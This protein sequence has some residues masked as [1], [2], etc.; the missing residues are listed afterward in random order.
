VFG[1][2]HFTRG[3][4]TADVS[5]RYY[6]QDTPQTMNPAL[7]STGFVYALKPA[8]QPT[9][10]LAQTVGARVTLAPT[11][12][13]HH[14]VT[15][16][17]DRINIDQTQT[18]PR[19]T[20]PADTFFTASNQDLTKTSIGYNTSVEGAL[21]RATTGSLTV[22]FDHYSRPE[23]FWY[24]GQATA[25]NMASGTFDSPFLQ[26]TA[27]S[28]TGYFAQAQVAFHDALFLTGGVRAER[29]SNFG[30]SLGT[31]VSPQFGLTFVHSVGAA[32]VK[33]RG[34]W[35]RAIRPPSPGEKAASGGVSSGYINLANPLLAPER[36]QGGDIGIDAVFGT[37][38]SLSV[39]YF[40]QTAE[41]LIT[42]TLLTETPVVTYQ[43]QNVGR[44]KNIGVEIEGAFA[45]GPVELKAQYGYVRSRVEDLGSSFDGD[46]LVGDSPLTTPQHTAG[47]TMTITPFAGTSLAAG[48][49]YVGS[50]NSYDYM[51]W[52]RCLSGKDPCRPGPGR[53]S[54]I[55]PYPSF[56]KLNATISQRITPAVSGFVSVDNLTNSTASEF[57]EAGAVMGRITTVG[58]Q[59]HP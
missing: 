42:T 51:S 29:N 12:W 19:L 25:A 36:Q 21:A 37:R 58:L 14:T 24:A 1:G 16:G 49:A 10:F 13:W 46:L 4:V 18:Q 41:D 32:T 52:Y 33:L 34:S 23:N 15:F 20:T 22:G 35:G 47:A 39:T 48:L 26:R 9:R 43:Y 11:G 30:D 53:R 7:A 31:P 6:T 2:V 5:G 27:T 50:W 40:N 55:A 28:N 38:G 57:H 3:L 44:V 45:A 59:V 17:I 54:Y 56:V 8:Y